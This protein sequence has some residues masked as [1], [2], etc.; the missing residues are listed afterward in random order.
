V[1]AL[2]LLR[3]VASP[4]ACFSFV[5]FD[6]FGIEPSGNPGD[7][8]IPM[9]IMDL[10]EMRVLDAG[11]AGSEH[12]L[13]DSE[14]K[15]TSNSPVVLPIPVSLNETDLHLTALLRLLETIT[16]TKLPKNGATLQ[17]EDVQRQ[18]S[19]L[20]TGLCFRRVWKI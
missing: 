12:N 3:A 19:R 5:E 14:E 16:V 17:A 8:F 2:L 4:L 7:I 1:D 11:T 15:L 9:V 20:R 10:E 18:I 13:D 6:E